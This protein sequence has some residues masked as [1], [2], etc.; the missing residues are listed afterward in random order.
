MQP[1]SIDSL[2][3]DIEALDKKIERLRISLKVAERERDAM[4]LVVARYSEKPKKRSSRK[5]DLGIEPDEIRGMNLEAALIHIAE[6]N[7]GELPSTAARE[8]L[9]RA[10][11]LTGEKASTSKMLWHYLQSSDQFE[12]NGRRGIY[13]LSS[14][15]E[16]ASSGD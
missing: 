7:D 16:V 15:S 6:H 8:L 9:E 10:E 14:G 11:I 4:A 12:K 13:R 1:L 2:T 3:S 5:K